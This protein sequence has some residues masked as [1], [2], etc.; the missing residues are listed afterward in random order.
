MSVEPSLAELSSRL[1][2]LEDERAIRATLYQYGHALDYGAEA[3]WVDCFVADAYYEVRYRAEGATPGRVD[4]HHGHE[5]LAA[6]AAGH[7]RAPDRWHKHV[8]VEPVIGIDGDRATVV[9]YFMRVDERDGERVIYAFGRYLDVLVREPDGRWRFAR[10]VA[11]V[12]SRSAAAAPR[13]SIRR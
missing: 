3:D 5:Q 4:Q 2:R 13:R 11:E 10:R 7:S 9:S 12:E 8:L 6:F 1:R